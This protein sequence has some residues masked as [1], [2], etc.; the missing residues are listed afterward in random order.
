MLNRYEMLR[1]V[2]SSAKPHTQAG[3]NGFA[4]ERNIRSTFVKHANRTWSF[5]KNLKIN[6]VNL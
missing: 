4:R 3:N 5:K 6:I 1:E 2:V